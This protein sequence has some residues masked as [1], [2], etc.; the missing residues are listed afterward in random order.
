MKRVGLLGAAAVAIGCVAIPSFAST[1]GWDG[2]RGSGGWGAD[3]PYNRCYRPTGVETFSG[4]VS[5]VTAATP[6]PGMTEGVSLLLTMK[7]MSILVHLGPVWYIEH[8]DTPIKVGDHIEVRGA[9]AFRAGLPAV[10]AAEVRKGESVLVL[11]DAS[12]IP[13]WAGWRQ[14][15]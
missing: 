2:W 9:R 5:E 13:A 7:T 8:L 1:D 3:S 15:R 11:R 10:I 6:M 4:D 14:A 12:G